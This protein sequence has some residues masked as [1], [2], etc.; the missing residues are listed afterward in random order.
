[1][2]GGTLAGTQEIFELFQ[3]GCDPQFVDYFTRPDP[4]ENEVEAFREF[5]FATTAE[6]L[7]RLE[8]QM[9]DTGT[10]SIA[11]DRSTPIADDEPTMVFYEFFRSRH[12]LATA[13]RL[14]N[15]PGPKRTAE[16]YVMISY[17]RQM[18]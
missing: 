9:I 14:A 16:G 17:L 3:H 15:L 7:G 12:L 4:S 8:K 18:G 6:E 5:L 10:N 1:M 2:T 11:L 13:R